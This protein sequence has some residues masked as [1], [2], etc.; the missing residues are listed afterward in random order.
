MPILSILLVHIHMTKLATSC[1]KLMTRVQV[2][3]KMMTARV[4]CRIPRRGRSRY[5]RSWATEAMGSRVRAWPGASATTRSSPSNGNGASSRYRCSQSR[6]RRPNQG[7]GQTNIM[8]QLVT[9]NNRHV[10]DEPPRATD[11]LLLAW[12]AWHAPPGQIVKSRGSL[13]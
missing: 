1:T 4:P 11:D 2:C 8:A 7:G 12:S 6:C 9:S 10:S 5:Q 13:P 3:R